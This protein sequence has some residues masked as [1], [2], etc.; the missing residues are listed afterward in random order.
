[1]GKEER[2]IEKILL[3]FLVEQTDLSTDRPE[4]WKGRYEYLSKIVIHVIHANASS[5]A[6]FLREA[7][8]FVDTFTAKVVEC[9]A[10]FKK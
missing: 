3:E 2:A 9:Q 10:N 5:K 4:G 6:D 7:S 1:M 8:V